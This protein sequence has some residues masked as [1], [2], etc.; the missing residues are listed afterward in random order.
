MALRRA[1]TAWAT[2]AS[3]AD[4]AAATELRH[5]P[6]PPSVSAPAMVRSRRVIRIGCPFLE[7]S[8]RQY[9]SPSCHVCPAPAQGAR[10]G[11]WYRGRMLEEGVSRCQ[12][13]FSCDS[14]SPFSLVTADPHQKPS[15]TPSSKALYARGVFAYAGPSKNGTFF[16]PLPWAP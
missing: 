13:H 5:R 14:L 6:T 10:T 4:S 16:L 3:S 11:Q 12:A 7:C 2:A 8:L 9:P 15:P 1:S